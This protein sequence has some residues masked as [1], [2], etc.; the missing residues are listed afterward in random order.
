MDGAELVVCLRR[1]STDTWVRVAVVWA[2]LA[3]TRS[4][5]AAG[6]LSGTASCVQ[7]RRIL[8]CPFSPLPFS[9]SHPPP[10][11]NGPPSLPFQLFSRL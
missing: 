8:C 5:Q 11:P 2:V 7:I 3:A 9:A 10:L 4:S 6:A 1:T